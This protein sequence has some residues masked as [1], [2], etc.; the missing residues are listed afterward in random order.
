MKTTQ[1]EGWGFHGTMN[2]K[3]QAAWPIAMTTIGKLLPAV[4]EEDIRAFLDSCH[5]RHFADAVLDAMF[6]GANLKKAIRATAEAWQAMHISR[7]DALDFDIP[8]GTPYLEAWVVQSGIEAIA[9]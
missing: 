5:G 9:S 4:D 1:N 7:R 6:Y 8:R 3:A 2:E